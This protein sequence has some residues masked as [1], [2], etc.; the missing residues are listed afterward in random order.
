MNRWEALVVLRQQMNAS[1]FDRRWTTFEQIEQIADD[2]VALRRSTRQR[3]G[4]QR[5]RS[6]VNRVIVRCRQW[7]RIFEIPSTR[8]RTR[9]NNERVISLLLI[10]DIREKKRFTGQRR[11]SAV[12]LRCPRH[13]RNILQ[14]KSQCK[15]RRRRRLHTHLVPDLSVDRRWECCSLSLPLHS[16]CAAMHSRS[17]K[18][19]LPRALNLAGVGASPKNKRERERI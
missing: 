13:K 14:R 5:T 9:W 19:C 17:L 3:N 12:H 15:R 2:L 11:E 6:G 4:R 1:R 18:V 8:T 16:R 7:Q 10:I